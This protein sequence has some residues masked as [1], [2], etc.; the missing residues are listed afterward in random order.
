MKGKQREVRLEAH[1]ARSTCTWVRGT[2][3][4]AAGTWWVSPV[5]SQAS[6]TIRLMHCAPNP[7]AHVPEDLGVLLNNHIVRQAE[8]SAPFEYKLCLLFPH[9]CNP[10]HPQ[11]QPSHLLLLHKL[12]GRHWLNHPSRSRMQEK[13]PIHSHLGT[14]FAQSR[15][16]WRL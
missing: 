12:L 8:G 7:N 4:R 10:S 3:N 15:V 9:P 2:G 14:P 16:K 13:H 5:L 11:P 1:K 6:P